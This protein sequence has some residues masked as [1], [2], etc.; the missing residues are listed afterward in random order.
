LFQADFPEDVQLGP[1][2]GV[3]LAAAV[4]EGVVGLGVG[5]NMPIIRFGILGS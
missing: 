4:L 1:N 3:V 2:T 5:K